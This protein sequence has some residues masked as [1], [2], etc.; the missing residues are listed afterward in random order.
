MSKRIEK[1]S[2]SILDVDSSPPTAVSRLTL[3]SICNPVMT[4][5]PVTVCQQVIEPAQEPSLSQP[6]VRVLVY[7]PSPYVS[8]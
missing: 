1:F 7:V 3:V 6:H 8:I 2:A 5:F 4:S